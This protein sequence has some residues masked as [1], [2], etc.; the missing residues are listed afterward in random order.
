MKRVVRCVTPFIVVEVQPGR[1]FGVTYR[2]HLQG[3]GQANRSSH[4]FLWLFAWFT[5][6]PRRWQCS[7]PK[8]L[9]GRAVSTQQTDATHCKK[10]GCVCLENRL[11][12]FSLFSLFWK[13]RV[14]L[15]D[16]VAVC[17]HVC[18]YPPIVVRQRLG[19]NPP[20]VARQRIR[21]IS[22]IV[23]RQRLGRNFTAV[24]NTHAIIEE[25]SDVSFS[26]WP[27]SYQGK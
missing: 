5:V 25:L 18:V 19:K 24:T 12:L 7:R 9:A 11:F 15:W 10:N 3:R 4:C 26:V 2:L 22:L 8:H 27:V 14:G 16:H 13:N 20:I 21:K 1:S 23:A 17:V 6:Q